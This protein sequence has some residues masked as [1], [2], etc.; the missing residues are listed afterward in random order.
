VAMDTVTYPDKRVAS[1][2]QQHFLPVKINVK[3]QKDIAKSYDVSWTPNV[4]VADE[5][6]KSYYRIEGFLPAEDFMAQLALG[7]GRYRL[8]RHE[9]PQARHHFEEV[10]QRH[11]GT[12]AGAQA[13]YWLGV[14]NYKNTK[15]PT[16]LRPSWDKLIKEYPNSEWAKRANVPKTN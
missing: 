2:L 8:E 4:V 3:D 16:Q 10:V 13:L 7:L 5:T 14:A 6:G 12:D 11:K 9:Y 1:F 15:D